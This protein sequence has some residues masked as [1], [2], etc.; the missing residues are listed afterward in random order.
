MKKKDV[1]VSTIK[2][3]ITGI[4]L[5]IN[6]ISIGSM[7]FSASSYDSLVKGF[8]NIRKK[9][10]KDLWYICI[11]II[12]G[13]CL[14]LLAGFNLISY[15]LN[16][17]QLQANILFIGFFIG[18][19]RVISK[20]KKLRLDKKNTFIPLIVI[21]ISMILIIVLENRM[22]LIKNN[23]LNTTCLGIITGISLFIPSFTS[24][25]SNIQNG[26][27][28][29]IKA[30][31]LS[32]LNDVLLIIVFVITFILIVLLLAKLMNALLKKNEN[33]TY[34]II[35]SLVLVN[36]IILI[37]QIKPFTINFV[38]IFT[39]VLAFLWGYIFAKNVERE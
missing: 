21:T 12:I 33:N 38:N 35:S 19:I 8:S 3:L 29:V 31:K 5:W 10:N 37:M 7:L 32:S 14:G 28:V 13:I 16:K 39:S 30:L 34:L 11:P 27:K 4:S 2:G 36:V 25:T 9:D 15:C 1:F 26:Y 20:K 6:N 23:L 24:F 18:G 17:Y 22:F